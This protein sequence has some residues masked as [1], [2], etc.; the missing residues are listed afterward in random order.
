MSLSCDAHD[1]DPVNPAAGL[2]LFLISHASSTSIRLGRRHF[3]PSWWILFFG[4]TPIDIHRSS[5]TLIFCWAKSCPPCYVH[6][7][8]ASFPAGVPPSSHW[9]PSGIYP[10]MLMILILSKLLL[11]CFYSWYHTM[12]WSISILLSQVANSQKRPFCASTYRSISLLFAERYILKKL[13]SR[14]S[15]KILHSVPEPRSCIGSVSALGPVH[16]LWVWR[17]LPISKTPL[18]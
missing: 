6:H 4:D 11:A 7:W 9:G 18:F 14:R 1:T 3:F 10:A 2:F 13:V 17:S 12:V 5:S 15:P 16:N 8:P